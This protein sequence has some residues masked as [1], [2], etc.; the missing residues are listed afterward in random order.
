MRRP[1]RVRSLAPQLEMV[2]LEL[3]G[4][5]VGSRHHRGAFGE[6]QE[7]LPQPQAVLTASAIEPL[8]PP[9]ASLASVG[10]VTRVERSIHPHPRDIAPLRA[11]LMRR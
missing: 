6:E 8:S 4:V 11:G 10:K 5:V 7:R 2:A 3:L 1:S 9:W